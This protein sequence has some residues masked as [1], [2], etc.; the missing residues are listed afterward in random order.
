ML[1]WKKIKYWKVGSGVYEV[2]LVENLPEEH[3]RDGKTA[4]IDFDQMKIWIEKEKKSDLSLL[5]DLFHELE[6]AIDYV[7]QEDEIGNGRETLEVR[8][9][10]R[11]QRRLEMMLDNIEAHEHILKFFREQRRKVNGKS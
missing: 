2:F 1:N 11:A 10:L 6:H 3:G 7:T 5:G 8:L 4:C 9:D